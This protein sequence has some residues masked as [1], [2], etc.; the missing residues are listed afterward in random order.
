M[1]LKE[2]A[3]RCCHCRPCPLNN[4]QADWQK[5][6]RWHTSN[7]SLFVSHTLT[8]GLAITVWEILP[9]ASLMGRV[10]HSP[11]SVYLITVS[12]Y[13]SLQLLHHPPSIK[14]LPWY[15]TEAPILIGVGRFSPLREY[16]LRRGDA[17]RSAKI[18]H[19]SSPSPVL[20]VVDGYSGYISSCCY[21][22]CVSTIFL[23][24]SAGLS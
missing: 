5:I 20:D 8:G 19:T 17:S 23:D 16:L 3:I 4:G 7:D 14:K 15:G 1:L 13:L 21:N 11:F 10:S 24:S 9:M 6:E 2:S 12:R 22:I 18:Y